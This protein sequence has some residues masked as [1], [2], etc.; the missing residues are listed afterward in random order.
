[1]RRLVGPVLLAALAGGILLPNANGATADPPST[2]T[3]SIGSTGASGAATPARPAARGSAGL[4]TLILAHQS[5]AGRTVVNHPAAV[6]SRSASQAAD[7]PRRGMVWPGCD[8]PL[9]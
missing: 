8:T 1:M 7:V 9:M 5:P 4:A 2:G 3:H 6:L